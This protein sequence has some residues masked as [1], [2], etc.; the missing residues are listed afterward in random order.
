LTDRGDLEDRVDAL[1]AE[2]QVDADGEPLLFVMAGA[3]P[4]GV[5]LEP[6]M[7]RHEMPENDMID[8]YEEVAIPKF[9]PEDLRRGMHFLDGEDVETLWS[10]LPEETREKELEYRLEHGHPIPPILQQ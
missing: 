5:D 6:Y 7:I 2:F 1:E 8:Y 3:W 10:I 4:E 9:L